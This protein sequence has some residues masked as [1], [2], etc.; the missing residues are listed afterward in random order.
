MTYTVNQLFQPGPSGVGPYGFVGGALVGQVPQVPASGSWLA[1]ML[2]IAASVQLPTT[3]WQT[4]DPERT[5]FATEAVCFALSDAN[6]SQ[7]A[8]GGFLQSAASGTV[9]Y[10]APDGTQVTIPVTP[11]PSNPAQN[12]T[13]APGYLDL[14]ADNVYDVKRLQATYVTGPLAVVKLSAGTLTY[15]AGAY[16]VGGL[17]G[18]TYHN[19]GGLSVPSSAIAG[20]GGVVTGVTV[21]VSSTVITTQSAHG[22][23]PGQSVYVVLPASS[24]V[25]LAGAG[26]SGPGVFALVTVATTLTFSIAAASSGTWSAGGTIY[27]C[28]VASMTADVAGVGSNAGPGT[29]V[30][31][32]TQNAQVFV[33]NIVPW[34]GSGFESN[35]ALAGRCQL[36]LAARSPNGPSGAYVYFAE[37]AFQLLAAATP[38]YNLTNGPVRATEFSTPMTGVV[39]VVVGS[40]T[41]ISTT[42]GQAVTPGVS[43]LAV[44]GI[45][46]AFPA[47]V[48]CAG[49]TSL[50]PAG[51]MTVTISGVLGMGA[52]SGV[53]GVNGTFLATYVSADSFSIPLDTTSAGTYAG[54]GSVEGGDLGQIDQLIQQNVVPDNT[55][56]ITS[57]ALA[58]PIQVT[59]TVVVPAAYVATY[60]IAVVQQLQ[61]QMTTYAFGGNSPGFA[62]A[63]DDI[64]GALEEAGVLVLGQASYVRQ[65]QSLSLN[66]LG[67]GAG[68]AFPS[69]FYEAVLVDPLIT[70]VGV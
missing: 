33:S 28:T 14:L 62:V 65:V 34:S 43:Q 20:T 57:S 22:L 9:L 67:A 21:G 48:T 31:A 47:V 1:T 55:V 15:V 63:Y 61:T 26:L 25:A 51:T 45:T 37:T 19:A 60:Q 7:M 32:I 29:V 18:A 2:T 58:L 49:P 13:G 70:V 11:D 68:V 66:S 17:G 40:A 59:A 27:L 46:N 8:Q 23:T 54:G 50:A 3:S 44:T 56:A 69:A 16:H 41:P 35:V 4:G 64:V 10:T 36:S 38:A 39:N 52:L 24:G 6:I 53:G 5:I 30:T 12:P 42:L